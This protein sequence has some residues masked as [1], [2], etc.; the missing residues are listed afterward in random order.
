MLCLDAVKAVGVNQAGAVASCVWCVSLL[1]VGATW[2][3][4]SNAPL[5]IQM[6]FRQ[7]RAHLAEVPDDTARKNPLKQFARLVQ[8]HDVPRS[9]R[10]AVPASLV[11]PASC[12]SSTQRSVGCQT[13]ILVTSLR[14]F[15][16]GLRPRASTRVGI[17]SDTGRYSLNG[18]AEHLLLLLPRIS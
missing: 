7:I 17:P 16:I 14:R 9:N 18:S 15:N 2:H 8:Q 10:Q 6:G 4:S 11:G 5:R 13:I 12:S 1:A 3:R